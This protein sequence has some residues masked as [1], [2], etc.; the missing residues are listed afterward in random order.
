MAKRSYKRRQILIDRFQYQLLLINLLYFFAI[1][2]IFSAALFVPLIIQLESTTLSMPEQEAVASQ[3]LSLHARV[4]P[5]LLITFLLFAIHSVF[6]SHRIAGPLMRFR[7]TFKAIASG[8]LSG[9]VILRKHDYLTNEADILNEMVAGLQT[10]INGIEAQHREVRA[11]FNEIRGGVEAGSIEGIRQKIEV[12]STQMQKLRECIDQFQMPAE[13]TPG[14]RDSRAA[15]VP[16][17][18]SSKS[19]SVTDS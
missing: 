11:V 8:D 16:V 1:L 6:V 13:K 19:S 3:F 15:V 7:N 14:E 9:R 17:P 5:A 2:L 12:L 4:W 18:A 10:K